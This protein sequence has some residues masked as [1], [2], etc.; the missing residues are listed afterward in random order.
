MPK[1]ILIIENIPLNEAKYF[2]PRKKI[3]K[4]SSVDIITL[5]DNHFM[6]S[7]NT[8]GI[9]EFID[10]NAVVELHLNKIEI[11]TDI[12]QQLSSCLSLKKIIIN[13]FE[14]LYIVNQDN[15][16]ENQNKILLKLFKNRNLDIVINKE[17]LII[18][19]NYLIKLFETNDVDPILFVSFFRKYA[20]DLAQYIPPNINLDEVPSLLSISL[21]NAKNRPSITSEL[22][23]LPNELA[24]LMPQGSSNTSQDRQN[25]KRPRNDDEVNLEHKKPKK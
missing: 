13:K 21:F 17:N 4:L 2:L 7:N 23:L 9:L 20:A 24:Q 11:S 8:I 6:G 15:R 14:F 10:K 22:H 19:S 16:N 12:A 18:F 25:L 5:N 1:D 3:L